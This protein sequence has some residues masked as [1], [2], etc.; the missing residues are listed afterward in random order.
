MRK[1]W[2][3]GCV[4]KAPGWGPLLPLCFNMLALPTSRMYWGAPCSRHQDQFSGWDGVGRGQW[5]GGRRQ[6]QAT[7]RLDKRLESKSKLTPKAGDRADSGTDCLTWGDGQRSSLGAF[8]V[9]GGCEGAKE[10]SPGLHSSDTVS[11]M[12]V[13][14]RESGEEVPDSGR[15]SAG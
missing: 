14:E 9:Q 12:V 15:N 6:I 3:G 1:G 10:S 13:T 4:E 2:G 7:Q 8:W 11:K 5:G